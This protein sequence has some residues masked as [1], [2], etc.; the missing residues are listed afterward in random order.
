MT[1]TKILTASAGA[2]KTHRLTGDYIDMLLKAGPEAYRHILAVTFTNK[3]TDEMKSRVIETLHSISK[4]STDPRQAAAH[5]CLTR[6]LHD[7]SGFSISTIDRF[8]QTVMRSFARE[9]GQYASYKV[10]LDSKAVIGRAVDM[11]VDSLSDPENED[12]LKWLEKYSFFEMEEGHSWD[13]SSL[14]R[15][16]SAYFFTDEFKIKSNKDGKGAKVAD[17]S[18][19]ENWNDD[20]LDCINSFRDGLSSY[21]RMVIDKLRENGLAPE[22]MKYM[23]RGP[24]MIFKHWD[25]G[26]VKAPQSEARFNDAMDSIGNDEISKLVYEALEFYYKGLLDYNTALVIRKNIYLLGIYS[27][28]YRNLGEFL[29]ENNVVLLSQTSD[30]INRIIDG[31]DTPFVYEK[32]GTRYDNLLL[33][34][35]QDTS[36]LQWKNF[37]PLFKESQ[38]N[39]HECLMVGDI[40]QSIYRWRGSDWRLIS[41]YAKS[42]LGQNNVDDSETLDDNW[43]SDS[44]IVDFNN[45]VFSGIS[46]QLKKEDAVIGDKVSKIYDS[47]RQTISEKRKDLHEGRVKLG[48]I[49]RKDEERQWKDIAL[50]KML[51]DIKHLIEAGYSY[52]QI[53]VLVRVNTDG[54]KVADF[55][56]S[57][58][59][60]VITEDSLLV[61]SSSCIRKLVSILSYYASPDDALTNLLVSDIDESLLIDTGG[62]LYERCEQIVRSGVL[63]LT[64]D[65]VPFVNAFMDLVIAYQDKY[66][67]SI[68]NFVK[69]W[70]ESGSGKSISAP[71][72]QNA[73]RVM[74]IHK[75]KGLSLK[76]VIL[77][78]LE[79]KFLPTSWRIPTIWCTTEGSERFKDIGLVPVKA[80]SSMKGTIFESQYNEERLLSYIDSINTAYVALTRAKS[81]LIIYCPEPN[82]KKDGTYD[83]N[84]FANCLY[85]RYHDELNEEGCCEFGT[86]A[87]HQDKLEELKVD[88][89]VQDSFLS[90]DCGKRLR[91]SMKGREYFAE[92]VSPRLRGIELH[93][94]LSG[95]DTMSDLESACGEDRESF[96]LLSKAMKQAPEEWFNGSYLTLNE[97]TVIDTNGSVYR[98][99]RILVDTAANTVKVIDYKFGSDNPRYREQVG[100]YCRLLLDMGFA[101]AEAYLWFVLNGTIE[102]VF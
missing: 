57:N 10:E 44:A 34:E 94:I 52:S 25:K 16:M 55:L 85:A 15:D 97:D 47:S 91:H 5:K 61:S 28:L 78:F 37:T 53:T 8:F 66:G 51:C 43:R 74:T 32:I 77:P 20:L 26:V 100:T 76:A 87:Y 72:G 89:M 90:T 22:D 6:I 71:D 36:I 95:V 75:S 46:Q 96:E 69:W 80:D 19:V 17:R 68:R 40:K 33:D 82:F 79:E 38:A 45:N 14:L 64:S 73:V 3:A 63:G 88:V 93:E 48:F 35:S 12:L 92:G 31:N 70:D 42:D 60:G 102:K 98:P 1:K 54:T 84:S 50:E 30:I 86:M 56:M 7:Y 4:D 101:K 13:I 29:S 81:D 41:E 67:S 65:Q 49:K 27:D 99:D 59:I 39:G 11:M 58:G 9:I 83:L 24:F 2:G 21:G 18:S 23:T 62:S